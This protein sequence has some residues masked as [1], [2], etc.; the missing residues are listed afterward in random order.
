MPV[1]GNIGLH[2]A[3]WRREFGGEIYLK[4]GSHGCINIPK[5]KAGELYDMVVIGTPVVMFY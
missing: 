1:N 4:S 5:D 3:T 2:D